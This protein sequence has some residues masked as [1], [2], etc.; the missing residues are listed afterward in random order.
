VLSGGVFGA[1]ADLAAAAALTSAYVQR[2]RKEDD[3][4]GQFGAPKR[5]REGS[6]GW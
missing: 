2:K 3:V 1:T 4:S 5:R 6:V